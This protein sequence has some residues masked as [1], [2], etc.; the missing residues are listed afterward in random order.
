MATFSSVV[1]DVADR[2]GLKVIEASDN[3]VVTAFTYPDGRSQRVFLAPVGQ[4]SGLTIIDIWSPVMEVDGALDKDLANRLL[5]A[6]GS[7]KV[8]YW[9]LDDLAGMTQLEH[10]SLQGTQVTDAGLVHLLGLSQLEY[11]HLGSTQVTD[12]GV[13]RLRRAL[14]RIVIV[15]WRLPQQPVRNSR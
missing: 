2:A 8:G 15:Y 14:R 12:A 4:L 1:R 13:T 5:K 10:I 7:H 3:L 6:N 9:A 11:L